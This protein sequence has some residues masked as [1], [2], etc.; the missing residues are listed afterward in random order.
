MLKCLAQEKRRQRKEKEA[1]WSWQGASVSKSDCC[2]VCW[3]EFKSWDPHGGRRERTWM[4]F[5]SLT[6]TAVVWLMNAAPSPNKWI[7]C[8]G[9][10][11]PDR[12]PWSPPVRGKFWELAM[13]A[14]YKQAWKNEGILENHIPNK[15]QPWIGRMGF[16]Q[17]GLGLQE[18]YSG[19]KW[20]L[21]GVLEDKKEELYRWRQ[22]GILFKKD[23]THPIAW[24]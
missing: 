23:S 20:D 1:R 13:C 19:R 3:P 8:N 24:V 10:K 4:N 22:E 17:Y 7:I 21:R 12:F 2:Q 18:K 6:P 9:K 14:R 11:E 15:M 16:C 5:F